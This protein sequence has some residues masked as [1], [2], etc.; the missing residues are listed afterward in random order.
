MSVLHSGLAVSCCRPYVLPVAKPNPLTKLRWLLLLPIPALW[1]FANFSGLLEFLEN[2]TVDWRFRARGEISAP[3][4]VVYVDVDSESITDLGN[5]PWDRGYF[6]E[7]GSAL[8]SAGKVRAVGI[9]FVFSEKGQAEL[10]DSERFTVGNR[11][12]AKF[13][14]EAPPVVLAAGYAASEDRDING[15]LIVR[16]LPTVEKPLAHALPPEMPEFR[17]G[18][19]VWNPPHVGLIDTIDGGT[20]WVPLFAT[21]QGITYSHMALE[22]ARLYWEIPHHG[23]K[24]FHD[25]VELRRED[26]SLVAAIPLSHGQNVEVNWFSRWSSPAQNPR[27]SFVEVLQHARN[28]EA[29]TIA[30]R[31]AA[32][33]F[34]AQFEDAVVLIGPADPLLQDI[35]STPLDAR[36]VPRVGIHGNLLKTIVSGIY[37]HRPGPSLQVGLILGLTLAVSLLAISGGRRGAIARAG[38]LLLLAVYTGAAFVAF[39][40]FH[41]ILPFTAP[42]GSAFSTSFIAVGWQLVREE[43][44]KGRIRSMFGTYVSPE[45]VSRMVESGE[46]PKLGGA[47]VEITAYFSDIQN[48]STFSERLTPPQVVELMNEYLTACTDIITAQGG[49]LDKYIGDA[50]V[51]M[52]GAPVAQADHAYRACVASQRVQLRLDELRKKWAGES[53]K[54]PDTVSRMRTRIGLNS[55]A[56]VVGNMG[57]LTR[58]NYTMM[59]DSVNLA[60]RLEGAAKTYGVAT[61]VTEGTKLAC[62]K[63][64][65]DCVFRFLDRI[66]VKGRSQPVAIYELIGLSGHLPPLA[67]DAMAEFEQGIGAYLRQDWATALL[68][69]QK[70]HELEQQWR[71]EANEATPASVYGQRCELLRLSP[72]G[73][74]WTGI[75]QMPTK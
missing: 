30:Q 12:L 4:K 36:P 66:L 60:A 9:D 16:K 69:F 42:L 54:W 70:A 53:N 34:F 55:G 1:S 56:A 72:P 26:Q 64:G 28:L 58:F 41:W 50:V 14:W 65:Q 63:H 23:I 40:R 61:L 52:F 19:S 43:R 74:N 20:R 48:F 75:W 21:A 47:E 62:E 73:A 51:A 71:G 38:A 8:L 57:S 15:G 29:E 44:Q 39:S 7:V 17:L 24:L 68:S 31:E 59:G 67:Q 32:E 35:A 22:L 11:R 46:D 10:V 33:K 37:I 25:R 45:L 13:L 49:T 6:A 3:I 5:W 27:A 2:K 18:P